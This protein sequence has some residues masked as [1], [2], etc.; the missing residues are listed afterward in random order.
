MEIYTHTNEALILLAMTMITI[1]RVGGED[2]S[3][4]RSSH[5]FFTGSSKVLD[6]E[7]NV[8]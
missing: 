5:S 2:N 3:L 6:L 1:P 7:T 4:L 8:N